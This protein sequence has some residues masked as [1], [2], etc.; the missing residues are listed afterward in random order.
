M[1][2]RIIKGHRYLCKKS[3]LMNGSSKDESYTKGKV[4]VGAR[5]Y[6]YPGNKHSCG[7]IIDN[8]GD[9]HAWAYHPEKQVWGNQCWTDFFDDLD[10]TA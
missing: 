2:P 10:K 3:V 9:Y 5:D 4:Y 7:Y 1:E 8:Q 6:G